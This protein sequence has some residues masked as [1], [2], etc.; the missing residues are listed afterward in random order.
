M[1]VKDRLGQLGIC[2][3]GKEE[4]GAARRRQ[5]GGGSLIPSDFPDAPYL[6]FPQKRKGSKEESFKFPIPE[7]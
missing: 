2:I 4:T 1:G 3:Q 6:R 7:S 5:K